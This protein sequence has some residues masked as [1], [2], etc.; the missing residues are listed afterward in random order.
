MNG[1]LMDGQSNEKLRTEVTYS[2]RVEWMVVVT[3]VVELPAPSVYVRVVLLTYVVGDAPGAEETAY[4]DAEYPVPIGATGDAAELEV[5]EYAAGVEA[6]DEDEA[7]AGE[8]GED[9]AEDEELEAL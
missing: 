5:Q 2:V 1:Q 6:E 4:E 7:L 3:T 8:T 9:D